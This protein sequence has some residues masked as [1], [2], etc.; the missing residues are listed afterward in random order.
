MIKMIKM[1]NNGIHNGENI[2]HQLQVATTPQ[3][4]NLSVRRIKNIIVPIPN[5][6]LD[7]SFSFDIYF[8]NK[9]LLYL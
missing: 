1:N 2:H 5:P 7:V 3:P 4:P 8:F 9:M 6:E